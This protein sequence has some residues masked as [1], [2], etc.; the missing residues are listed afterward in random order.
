MNCEGKVLHNPWEA[1]ASMHV[2]SVWDS[3]SQVVILFMLFL[4]LEG[5]LNSKPVS[6]S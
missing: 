1:A 6:F 3:R 2:L 4:G 5:K